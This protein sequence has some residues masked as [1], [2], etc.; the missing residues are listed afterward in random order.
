MVY[1]GQVK[2]DRFLNETIFKGKPTGFFVDIGANNGITFSNSYFFEKIGWNGICFEPDPDTFNQLSRNRK[3]ICLQ[4]A[5]SNTEGK[6]DFCI[7]EGISVLNGLINEYDQKHIK[8]IEK[9]SNSCTRIVQVDTIRAQSIF[10]QYN[11]KHIDFCS[12]DTEG[13]ELNVLKS[14]DFDK[15]TIDCFVIENNYCGNEIHD[16]MSNFGYG[17]VATIAGDEFYI[18]RKTNYNVNKLQ[19]IIHKIK[20][21]FNT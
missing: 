20:N 11:V 13:S 4:L 5:V 6:Q 9:E 17:K 21:K 7:V 3:C 1:Y 10:D 15:V 8:R 14:I 2:Q 16:F 12:I 18:N 19:V